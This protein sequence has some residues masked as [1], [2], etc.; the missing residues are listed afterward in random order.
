MKSEKN[1]WLINILKAVDA[2]INDE[3][4]WAVN[5]PGEEVQMSIGEAYLQQALRKL[6][7]V[8]ENNDLDALR[9]II[10]QSEGDV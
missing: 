10:A 2:Q 4:L 7:L 5:I 3:T 9:E 1:E 6:H 8:I